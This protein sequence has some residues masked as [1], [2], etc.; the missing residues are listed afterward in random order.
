MLTA[1][2][3]SHPD[4]SARW[5]DSFCSEDFAKCL[6][7]DLL[8]WLGI[9]FGVAPGE[10]IL[11]G[12]SLTGL[13]AV[14]AAL[15][16]PAKFPRVLSMSGSFWWDGSRLP[17]LVTQSPCSGVAFRLTVGVDE[18][19]VNTTHKNHGLDLVQT[20][21]Q[22]DCNRMMRDALR[23]TGHQVSYLEHPGG[24]DFPSWRA[25]LENSLMSLLALPIH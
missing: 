5:T 14:H 20:E 3:S 2:V 24:H 16:Y 9:E 19:T 13:S 17:L 25:E 1:Y 23:G 11:A 18:T 7:F 22:V 10:N 4:S 6:V 12:L 15:K 21:S 8:P